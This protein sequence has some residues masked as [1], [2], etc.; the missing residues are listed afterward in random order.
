MLIHVTGGIIL[1]ALC[2]YLGAL[3][4][5]VKLSVLLC[6]LRLFGAGL[7]FSKPAEIDDVCHGERV[8]RRQLPQLP[9]LHLP[10]SLLFR[11]Q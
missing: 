3:G 8:I 6:Q 11:L 9:L 1:Q 7:G 10:Q 5:S 4:Q 2:L